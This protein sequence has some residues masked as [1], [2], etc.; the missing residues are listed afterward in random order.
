[1]IIAIE[2]LFGVIWV[3]FVLDSPAGFTSHLHHF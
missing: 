2:H 1:L 3:V